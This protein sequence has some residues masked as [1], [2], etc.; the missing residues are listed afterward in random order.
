MATGSDFKSI[1]K[2]LANWPFA[3]QAPPNTPDVP[4]WNG[5]ETAEQRIERGLRQEQAYWEKLR[6]SQEYRGEIYHQKLGIPAV[7]IRSF[8]HLRALSRSSI[9]G[10][11]VDEAVVEEAIKAAKMFRRRP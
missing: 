2:I 5:F 1:T 10:N 4:P 11:F 6:G 3:K 8:E 7:E 9:Q